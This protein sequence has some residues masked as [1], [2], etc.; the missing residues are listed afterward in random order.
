MGR[1]ETAEDQP[2]IE[3]L[4]ARFKDSHFRFRELIIAVV[5]SD[6]FLGGP[7]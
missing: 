2:A 4:L 3:S 7:S 1:Q 6:L 5:T